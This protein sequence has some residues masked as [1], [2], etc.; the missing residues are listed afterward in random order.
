MLLNRRRT[1]VYI[2]VLVIVLS[3]VLASCS[4]DQAKSAKKEKEEKFIWL[5]YDQA[6]TKSSV[7]NI[8]TL[9]FFYSDNCGWCRKMEQ[10]NFA[11]KEVQ[12]ILI[13]Y[14]ASVRID[15]NSS[16]NVVA[17]AQKMTEKQLS[18]ELYNV[19]GLPTIWFLDSENQKIANLPGFVPVDTFLD[20]LHYIGE[21]YYKE[22]TFPEYL[23]LKQESQ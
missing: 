12:D 14:F 18:T 7:E 16:N 1:G 15:S 11:N 8:P 13:E 5:P 3:F 20:I 17:G 21:G 2:L 4:N 6:L 9:L 19:T 23:E 22:H 10:E